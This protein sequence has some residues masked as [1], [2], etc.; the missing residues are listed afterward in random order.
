MRKIG[1]I[2]LAITLGFG[3]CKK[4]E[5]V[6]PF[7]GVDVPPPFGGDSLDI[8]DSH[9]VALQRDVFKPT[10]ANSGCHDGTFEPDFRT[11]E[12]TYNTLVNH[13]IIKNNPAETYENR[14]VPGNLS[15]SMLWLRLN[16]D[17]DGQSGIMPLIV[18][19]TND[20]SETSAVHLSN[21]R[22]WIENGALDMFGSPAPTGDFQPGFHGV[23]AEADGIPCEVSGR[24]KVPAGSQNVTIWVAL[25]DKETSLNQFTHNKVRMGTNVLFNY[26]TVSAEMNLNYNPT[27]ISKPGMFG[28]SVEY[29]HSFS[30]STVSWDSELNH[31]F[32]VFVKDPLQEENTELPQDGS[33]IHI[34]TYF[35]WK[36]ES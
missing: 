22:D 3:A 28:S 31:Y 15:Q 21:I 5:N 7:I 30:F 8:E 33:A 17:I 2:L 11:V 32:R 10:C 16:E 1:Y 24:I 18:D 20:W 23:Y 35:S 14:V 26:D 4:T 34:K 29:Y 25:S 6:N 36:I 13:P 12:S 27:P 9:I 19:P